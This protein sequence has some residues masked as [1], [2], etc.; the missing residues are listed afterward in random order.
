MKPASSSVDYKKIELK[1]VGPRSLHSP[2]ERRRFTPPSV[3]GVY[4][5]TVASDEGL[6]VS[7]VGQASNLPE[8]VSLVGEL[9]TQG[10][11]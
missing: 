2:E 4:L 10:E 5:W 6:K 11:G 1:W 8:K 9:W 7:Y 3:G